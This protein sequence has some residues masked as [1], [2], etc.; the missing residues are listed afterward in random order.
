MLIQDVVQLRTAYV[1]E[2]TVQQVLFF[3][4]PLYVAVVVSFASAEIALCDA[5]VAL[6]A[7]AAGF[8]LAVRTVSGA[9]RGVARRSRGPGALAVPAVLVLTCS[10]LLQS[11][12]FGVNGVAVPASA[13]RVCSVP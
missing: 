10:T 2:S 1:L 6:V 3:A 5:A 8:V 9:R 13:A 7:G 11:I 4:G 12:V